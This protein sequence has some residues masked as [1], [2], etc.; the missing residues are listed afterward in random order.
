MREEKEERR[1][2][3]KQMCGMQSSANRAEFELE[4]HKT[5]SG[6]RVREMERR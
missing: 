6:E 5:P 2:D 3:G 4:S 1:G